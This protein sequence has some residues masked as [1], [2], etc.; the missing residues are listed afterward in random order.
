MNGR[1]VRDFNHG[2]AFHDVATDTSDTVIGFVVCVE[3]AAI[4]GAVGKGHMRVVQV[5]VEENP[6]FVF[7][8]F[9]GFRQHF[10]AHDAAAFVGASPTGSAAV[11]EDG[12]THQLTHGRHA[13]DA[14]FAGLTAGVENV[15]LVKVARG[16][17]IAGFG[18]CFG[19]RGL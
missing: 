4:V 1:N 15:V 6:A 19:A 2:I 9:F 18:G 17:V 16:N 7:E 5:A 8:E 10:F 14:Q 12:D 11:V 3:V 13:E